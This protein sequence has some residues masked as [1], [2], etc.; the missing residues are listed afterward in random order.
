MTSWDVAAVVAHLG[1]YNIR[2]EVE[3]PHITR[4]IKRVVRHRSFDFF[5]LV[6]FPFHHFYTHFYTRLN[7][8]DFACGW[9]SIMILQS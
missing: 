7:S 8:S 5:N 9:P 6:S 3:V 2:S 1:D 4:R